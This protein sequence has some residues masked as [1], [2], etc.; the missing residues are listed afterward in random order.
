MGVIEQVSL[1]VA[2]AAARVPGE[3]SCVIAMNRR[4][5]RAMKITV[6]T[7]TKTKDEDGKNHREEDYRL[8]IRSVG[9]SGTYHFFHLRFSLA[10]IG[11]FRRGIDNLLW[12]WN[13]SATTGLVI[14][15]GGFLTSPGDKSHELSPRWF[16]HYRRS[17]STCFRIG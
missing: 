14:Y 6:L 17:S 5:K 1:V 7:V 9:R 15:R 3:R 10:R 2:L 8:A 12:I 11:P 16:Y 4:K 13:L